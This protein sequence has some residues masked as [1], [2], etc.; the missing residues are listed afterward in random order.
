MISRM[1]YIL[2]LVFSLAFGNWVQDFDN[3]VYEQIHSRWRC[4]F[5]DSFFP[6]VNRIGGGEVYIATNVGF[7]F[8]G[9]EDM[10]NSAKLSTV[11][12]ILSMATVKCLKYAVDRER[13]DKSGNSRWDSS[14][15]SGHTAA[16]FT[17]AYV[18]GSQYPK[19]RIPLYAFALSVGL[20]RIY[21]G[22]HYPTDVIAGAVIGT[23]GGIVVMKNK[24]FILS[25][26]L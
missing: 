11:G 2:C 9:D 20:A 16:A 14:F 4:G 18:Y 22:E 3:S 7:F 23:V 13:P 8:L 5:S 25:I 15:P 10:K 24:N 19:S 26:K 1:I 12:C 6:I 17:M 21:L